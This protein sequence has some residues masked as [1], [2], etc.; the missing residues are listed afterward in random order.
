MKYHALFDIFEKAAKLNCRLLQIIGGALRFKAK[1]SLPLLCNF[2]G[3][4][5]SID[6]EDEY[7][8]ADQREAYE[9]MLADTI[10]I[11]FENNQSKTFIVSEIEIHAR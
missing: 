4:S 3:K 6:L 7:G 9:K 1:S 8:S 10:E 11:R 5:V 2:S